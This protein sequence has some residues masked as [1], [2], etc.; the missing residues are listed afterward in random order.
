MWNIDL[1]T[2]NTGELFTDIKLC[3][4]NPTKKTEVI[5][6]EQKIPRNAIMEYLFSKSRVG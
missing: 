6:T 4:E 3:D 5:Y 2:F 1:L